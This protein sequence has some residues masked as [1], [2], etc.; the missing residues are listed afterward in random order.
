MKLD[1]VG[2]YKLSMATN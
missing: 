1:R 2:C